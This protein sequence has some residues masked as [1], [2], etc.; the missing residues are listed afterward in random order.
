MCSIYDNVSQKGDAQFVG[1][2]SIEASH[3]ACCGWSKCCQWQHGYQASAHL[4]R[5][6]HTLREYGRPR[7]LYLLHRSRSAISLIVVSGGKSQRDSGA[8][9]PL[10]TPWRS[11]GCAYVC[12]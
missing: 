3:S 7:F 1:F 8:V 11:A 6:R 10:A 5:G 12:P 4:R 2:R 9:L